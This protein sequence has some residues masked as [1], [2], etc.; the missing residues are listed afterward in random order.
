MVF[1]FILMTEIEGNVLLR[2]QNLQFAGLIIFVYF[3]CG[4][5]LVDFCIVS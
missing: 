3:S 1:T 5:N 2:I 4:L